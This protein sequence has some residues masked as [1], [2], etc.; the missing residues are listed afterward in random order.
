MAVGN[1]CPV[2]V[3]EKMVEDLSSREG[4]DRKVMA[5]S[6]RGI[7]RREAICEVISMFMCGPFSLVSRATFW[8]GFNPV[9]AGGGSVSRNR[10]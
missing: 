7:G 4:Y 8:V 2:L 10:T 6:L 9:Q 3:E 5:G 1:D